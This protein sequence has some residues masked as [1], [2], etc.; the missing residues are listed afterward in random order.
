MITRTGTAPRRCK[1]DFK[2]QETEAPFRFPSWPF[3]PGVP[4]VP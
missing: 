3:M 4:L 1:R 2:K